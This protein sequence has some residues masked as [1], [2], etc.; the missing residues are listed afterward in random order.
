MKVWKDREGREWMLD[1][2]V[3]SI[4]KVKASTGVDLLEVVTGTLGEKLSDPM[5]FC[6]IVWVLSQEQAEKKGITPEQFGTALAGDCVEAVS[7]ALVEDLVD[8]FPLQRRTIF[9]KVLEKARVIE[10]KNLDAAMVVVDSPE[11]MAAMEKGSQQ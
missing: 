9:R 11:L 1:I 4:R 7:N 6:D 10:K 8:F 5:V 2:N 3:S